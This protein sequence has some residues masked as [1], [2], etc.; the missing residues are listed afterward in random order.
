M[1]Q[2]PPHSR[3]GLD[4]VSTS[5]SQSSPHGRPSQHAPANRTQPRTAE[6][7]GSSIIADQSHSRTHTDSSVLL[8]PNPISVFDF[9]IS[10]RKQVVRQMDTIDIHPKTAESQCFRDPVNQEHSRLRSHARIESD[11]D[12]RFPNQSTETGGS[13]ADA[14]RTHPE[15]AEY[16][17]SLMMT[18][19]SHSR[20]HTDSSA[21]LGPNP[22]SGSDSR[23][24]PRKQV[25]R[26]M[27]AIRINPETAESRGSRTMTSQPPNRP[28]PR[29]RTKSNLDGQSPNW[30]TG[31]GH[32]GRRFQPRSHEN[33][34]TPR[35]FD[36]S[37]PVAQLGTH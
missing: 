2:H 10:P 20:A 26:Q 4:R 17:G 6:Y 12:V 37:Q 34:G 30:S 14:N 22:I 8:G 11:L 9:R 13:A 32:C 25:V 21:P 23:I 35:L 31:S 18:G 7:R 16:R 1:H 33:S 36:H 3:R 15:T 29:N 19:R 5:D 28:R 27:D 24:S